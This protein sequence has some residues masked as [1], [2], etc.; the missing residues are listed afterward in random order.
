MQLGWSVTNR[1]RDKREKELLD[2]DQL[3]RKNNA[4]DTNYFTK[5]C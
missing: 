3:S 1:V 5:N 4:R 2:N